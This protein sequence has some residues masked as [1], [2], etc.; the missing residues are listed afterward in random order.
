MSTPLKLRVMDVMDRTVRSHGPRPALRVKR[1]A[2]WQTVTWT[3]YYR[4]VRQIARALIALDV[5]PGSCVTI[6][7]YNSPEWFCADVGAIYAGLVPAG[8]YATNSP[9]Q[10]EYVAKH[11][12][13]AVAF[14]EDREQ[15]AKFLAIRDRL[16]ALKAIVLMRGDSSE[17]DVS[18]WPRF[19]QL[20]LNTSE[21]ELDR[22][23]AAQSPDAMAT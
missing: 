20:G 19:L 7:G 11:C 2:G 9:E 14:V 6:I 3:E 15:L 22:R 21:H 13:A 16:P 8:I 23:V 17:R 1:N 4:Q 10:C 18:S 5:A 12:E